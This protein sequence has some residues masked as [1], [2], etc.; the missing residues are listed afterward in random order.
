MGLKLIENN[1]GFTWPFLAEDDLQVIEID[2]NIMV[3]KFKDLDT[4]KKIFVTRP[5][6]I[7]GYLVMLHHYNPTIPYQELDWTNQAFWIQLRHLLLEHLKVDT[8]RKIGALMGEV[9]VVDPEDVIPK[10]GDPVKVCVMLDVNKPLRR[11]VL[12]M[13]EAGCTRWIRFF[14]EKQPN[15]V[16][17]DCFI[18][19]HKKGVCKAAAE[20]L[21]ALHKKAHYFGTKKIQGKWQL[22][23]PRATIQIPKRIQRNSIKKTPFVPPQDGIK[24]NVPAVMTILEL[25]IRKRQD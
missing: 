17:N 24:I 10:A 23:E 22:T 20:Y 4:L 19:N 21:D 5:W 11:G 9:I 15:K 3:F 2:T 7:T 1:I 14:Y 13:T 8:V 12:V 25:K 16:C 6:S 18:L